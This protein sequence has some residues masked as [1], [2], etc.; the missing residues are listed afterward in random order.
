[1]CYHCLCSWRFA[2]ISPLARNMIIFLQTKTEA[3]SKFLQF[4]TACL[5][6]LDA[7]QKIQLKTNVRYTC[8]HSVDQKHYAGLLSMIMERAWVM[9]LLSGNEKN[10]SIKHLLS[11]EFCFSFQIFM[12]QIGRG[13]LQESHRLKAHQDPQRWR[14]HWG[15][16]VDSAAEVAVHHH[17]RCRRTAVLRR[18]CTK[19]C[20]LTC[21]LRSWNLDRV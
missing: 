9:L 16:D 11:P 12:L 6:S 19:C 10:C 20:A 15:Q 1:M 4:S 17:A 18:F 14:H 21:T 2:C 8:L 5:S 7:M 13:F 3:F